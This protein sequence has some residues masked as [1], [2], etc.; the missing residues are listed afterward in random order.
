MP[1]TSDILE[2]EW[3]F[4]APSTSRAIDWLL[5]ANVPGYAVVPAGQKTH[6]DTYYDT[7][8]WRLS[9]GKFTCRVRQKKDG[10]E[11]T[12]KGMAGALDGMRSRR[13]LTERLESHS[14]GAILEAPGPCGTAIRLI[15]GRRHPEPL[16]TLEQQR[17]TFDLS[18]S[19]GLLGEISV[20]DTWVTEGRAHLAR[21]EVEVDAAAV[22]RARRFVELFVVTAGL[23]PGTLSKFEF[24]LNA[25]GL[26]VAPTETTLGP[27]TVNDAMTAAVVGFAIMRKHFA[28]F[29][30]NEPGTRL[31]EDIEALHDMRV[32]ARR[33]RA[34]MSAFRPFLGPRVERFREQLGWVA[35][36]L[37]E[38]RDLD[39]QL[40]RMAEWRAEAAPG[41]E[42]ALD[43]VGALLNA[44]RQVARTRMLAALNSR[45][46]DILV[47]RFA[48]LLRRG[49]PRSWTIGREPI[50]QV[51][52]DLLEKRYRRLRRLGDAIT[53]ASP[54][55]AY[56]MLRIEAK[57]VRY[58]LEF[59]GPIYGKP[60]T[61]F[62]GR[63]TALQDLLGLHQDADVAVEMLRDMAL[64]SGRKL[65]P[66][67]LLVMGGISERYRRHAGELRLGFPA[68]YRKISG[69]EWKT[70]RKTVE[71]RRPKA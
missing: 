69:A 71:G 16:F 52:P 62:A 32:A 27:A 48:S 26:R 67:T 18:D 12:L 28:V 15:V 20:D 58:A 9:R 43:A 68:L 38:V 22:E 11:L 45:R 51:A 6:L 44:R 1:E 56:H 49:S 10:A 47:E 41:Q 19:E 25:A 21:V 7:A 24:G 42:L 2:V 30:A 54:P 64:V 13:E 59:V 39:V 55:E 50:L 3:Q 4:D 57:K 53:P 34:A 35:A 14:L 66:E 60:A 65:G 40:E 36:A 31:G 29:L 5:V 61:D 23:L 8:D 63:L 33:L 70:L 37:G 17:R 46:Y